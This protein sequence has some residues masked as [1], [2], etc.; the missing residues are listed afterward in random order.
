VCV[1][2]FERECM[3][4]KEGE[5]LRGCVWVWDKIFMI[6]H[7]FQNNIQTLKI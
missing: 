5:S 3:R 1:F 4:E 2:S 6:P 7:W